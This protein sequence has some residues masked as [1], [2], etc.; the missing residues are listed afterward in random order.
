ML[1]S[2]V[3]ALQAKFSKLIPYC[4]HI[5]TFKGFKTQGLFSNRSWDFLNER[6]HSHLKKTKNWASW[7]NLC[8]AFAGNILCLGFVLKLLNKCLPR[9]Q[10]NTVPL[11][12]IPSFH[13]FGGLMACLLLVPLNQ[14]VPVAIRKLHSWEALVSHCTLKTSVSGQTLGCLQAKCIFPFFSE[15][16]TC[17]EV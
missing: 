1:S 16:C 15:G 10:Q 7:T 11:A 4:A 17:P 3:T 6:N 2:F 5:K 9:Q 12:G 8:A 13:P 14:S